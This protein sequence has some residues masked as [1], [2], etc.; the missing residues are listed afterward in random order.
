MNESLTQPSADHVVVPRL[1]L[2]LSSHTL[3]TIYILEPRSCRPLPLPPPAS[4]VSPPIASEG[5]F[6]WVRAV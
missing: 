4:H 6:T 3:N 5:E 2:L 1:Y